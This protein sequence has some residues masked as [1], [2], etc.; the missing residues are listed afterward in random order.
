MVLK[1][2]LFKFCVIVSP[3]FSVEQPL[4]SELTPRTTSSDVD[5][6]ESAHLRSS[7]PNKSSESHEIGGDLTKV[8]RNP[9]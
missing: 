8:A 9:D 6:D 5:A 1:F 2:L 7:V 4:T 3:T